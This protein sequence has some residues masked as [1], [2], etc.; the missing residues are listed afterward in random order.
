MIDNQT[1]RM[2]L[3]RHRQSGFPGSIMDVFRAA[4]QGVDLIG[5]YMMQQQ[6]QV[7]QQVQ[8]QPQVAS[9]PEQYEQGLRPAHQ[10][11][12]TN[13]SMIFPNVPPNTPFNT[14]GMKAPI[15]IQKFDEQGHLVKS[16]ENVPPGVRNLPTGPQRG[17]VLETPAQ[18]RSGGPSKEEQPSFLSRIGLGLLDRAQDFLDTDD[19]GYITNESMDR[20]VNTVMN[21]PFSQALKEATRPIWGETIFQNFRPVAYPNADNVFFEVKSALKGKNNEPSRDKQGRY[22]ISEEA[23][24]RGLGLPVESHYWKESPYKPSQSGDPNQRYYRLV[25]EVLDREKIVRDFGD[26]PVGSRIVTDGLVISDYYRRPYQTAK[27]V[28]ADPMANFT[29]SVGEDEKGKYISLYDKYDLPGSANQ[30]I[31]PF[32]IYDRIYVDSPREHTK[33]QS[34]GAGNGFWT[35]VGVSQHIANTKGGRGE[36]YFNMADTIA[37]HESAHTMDPNMLQIPN[38]KKGATKE[39]MEKVGGKGAFQME[40]RS[41]PTYWRRM[42]NLSERAGQPLPDWYDPK[43]T[44]ARKLT[45]D[46]QKALHLISMLEHDNTDMSGYSEGTTTTAEQWGR[47]WKGD[48]KSSSIRAF[49]VSREKAKKEGITRP[50]GSQNWPAPE[51]PEEPPK[52]EKQETK[53]QSWY[54]WF[55]SF[56]DFEAG[57]PRKY[58]G[59]GALNFGQTGP[60]FET[61]GPKLR[62]DGETYQSSRG[63]GATR[64]S[65]FEDGTQRPILLGAAEVYDEPISSVP[66]GYTPETKAL[67]DEG[68]AGVAARRNQAAGIGLAAVGD[69]FS[70]VQRYGVSA[71]LSLAMGKQPNLSATPLLD[72]ALGAQ[73]PNA[74]P[75]EILGIQNPYGAVATDIVTDPMAAFGLA[76]LG[77]QG[78]K[79]GLASYRNYRDIAGARKFADKYGY[80]APSYATATST[81]AT[82]A[83]IRKMAEEH[84]T[85]ARGVTVDVD[86]M[87]GF[88]R[89]GIEKELA[90]SGIDI[91]K[92][93]VGPNADPAV[94]KQFAERS[95]LTI[96]GDTG[97]GRAGLHGGHPSAPNA[98]TSGLYTSNSFDTAKGYTY[99]EGYIGTL[100]RQGLDFTGPRSN[101]LSGNDFTINRGLNQQVGDI[102]ADGSG[103]KLQYSPLIPERK[104]RFVSK[105][106][107]GINPGPFGRLGPDLSKD[108]QVFG[109]LTNLLKNPLAKRR[110]NKILAEEKALTTPYSNFYN[111]MRDELLKTDAGKRALNFDAGPDPIIGQPLFMKDDI[112]PFVGKGGNLQGRGLDMAIAS[113][114]YGPNNLLGLSDEFLRRQSHNLGLPTDPRLAASAM[115]RIL[116]GMN[117]NMDMF[118]H[119]NQM[120][121]G[122]AMKRAV[123]R[124]GLARRGA[125]YNL[126]Q[127]ATPNNAI[128]D[129]LPPV[130][131]EETLYDNALNAIGRGIDDVR[132]AYYKAFANRLHK[133]NYRK[134]EFGTIGKDAGRYS[135]YIFTGEPGTKAPLDIIGMQRIT[136]LRD[137]LGPNAGTTG[138]MRGHFGAPDSGLSKKY[139]KGG[140][141][142]QYG[143]LD[144]QGNIV[145]SRA[146]RDALFPNG[147][148]AQQQRQQSKKS[149]GTGVFE[150]IRMMPG[151]GE[152]ID[153]AEVGRAYL[154]GKDFYGEPTNA[155]AL[156]GTALAGILV[157]NIVETPAKAAIKKLKNSP[158]AKDIEKGFDQLVDWFSSDEYKLRLKSQGQSPDLADEAV[159]RL[160]ETNVVIKPDLPHDGRGIGPNV[161]G[162][163][164]YVEFKEGAPDVENLSVHEFGHRSNYADP[165]PQ[166]HRYAGANF[167]DMVTPPQFIRPKHMSDG[168]FYYYSNP[169][170]IRSRSLET[171]MY[172][173]R[174]G[175]SFDEIVEMEKIGGWSRDQLPPNTRLLISLYKDTPKGLRRFNSYLNKMLGVSVAVGVGAAAAGEAGTE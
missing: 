68:A 16:Y 23:W 152:L 42:K 120:A 75:S 168:D 85:F 131:R 60:D 43:I 135:H 122:E 11:G 58:Q 5:Q 148:P 107:A 92:V 96:P 79:G 86:A 137:Q 61:Y 157:P 53:A 95:L 117:K 112:L 83:A 70:T 47:G 121:Q 158:M 33:M 156:G 118:S 6:Q 56:F 129:Y 44:D 150:G 138:G 77:K 28:V 30:I 8:Q 171:L 145:Y 29:I 65:T 164:G 146:E 126:Q 154:T 172:M 97:Y 63:T 62:I 143:S 94:T 144:A 169:D 140:G 17:T 101:W 34:G 27:E 7:Q 12:N 73:S 20:A 14:V 49:D 125:R 89:D 40:A 109:N 3:Q 123:T 133:Q 87:P 103:P 35:P 18:M 175:K 102:I 69:Y 90:G 105:S 163:K 147:T 76:T 38:R 19:E 166:G 74:F 2:L 21:N 151:F 153:F 130:R 9:T 45:F 160:G 15:N 52:Q 22:T 139:Q 173:K 108:P 50:Q 127:R 93:G 167:S 31:R 132:G 1:R 155:G 162:G 114:K 32:E 59:A 115:D 119:V 134:S 111:D 37:Y 136:G 116:T 142:N 104:A 72:R 98:P 84:N 81:E 100:R 165:A 51:G 71:P 99:G 24:R 46:Q 110:F 141:V 41:M 124:S 13:Q 78:V 36:Q 26:K 57:G 54:D 161:R 66:E 159:R 67:A 170:E 128:R 88:R 10:A 64:I 55:K 113:A 106:L 149:M 48:T 25:P 4:E 80:K 39:S 82:D 174:T 91:N